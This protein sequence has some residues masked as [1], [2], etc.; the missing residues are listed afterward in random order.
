MG[1]CSK[2]ISLISIN[3][4][5]GS[6]ARHWEHGSPT[7]LKLETD[8]YLSV[9]WLENNGNVLSTYSWGQIFQKSSTSI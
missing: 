7:L 1:T 3:A 8:N 9:C 2:A 6:Q 4:A 5:M